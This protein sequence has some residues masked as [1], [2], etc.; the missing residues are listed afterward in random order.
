LPHHATADNDYSRAIG[1]GVYGGALEITGV[2]LRATATNGQTAEASA[3]V[4][5][6]DDMPTA[7]DLTGASHACFGEA[8]PV[9][10]SFQIK[11][12][13]DQGFVQ[14]ELLA[15]GS[16]L[17]LEAA[18]PTGF[19][20]LAG[21]G[22][23]DVSIDL[24]AGLG[25]W[26]FGAAASAAAAAKLPFT[27]V[28]QDGDGDRRTAVHNLELDLPAAIDLGAN[29]GLL[30][31]NEDALPVPLVGP[32]SPY[33][34][35]YDNSPSG[36]AGTTITIH[37]NSDLVKG[38]RFDSARLAAIQ[39]AAPG[40][41]YQLSDQDHTLQVWQAGDGASAAP[42]E[43]ARV[44]LGA[45]DATRDPLNPIVPVTATLLHNLISHG[46]AQAD[47]S[48]APLDFS[49]LPILVDLDGGD[50]APATD[51]LSLRI[52]DDVPRVGIADDYADPGEAQQLTALS[53]DS[54]TDSDTVTR[55]GAGGQ[56]R[57]SW[58]A[59]AANNGG[60]RTPTAQGADGAYGADGL[61]G[62]PE[63]PGLKQW[64][65]WVDVNRDGVED[66][67]EQFT[68]AN[69]AALNGTGPASGLEIPG[70]GR[71]KFWDNQPGNAAGWAFKANNN[72]T[73]GAFDFRVSIVDA[74]GDRDQQSHRLEVVPAGGEVDQN[75]TVNLYL[76]L[77]NSTSMQGSDPATIL[78]STKTRLEA[79]N[80]M[81]F[82]ALEQ[83]VARAGYGYYTGQ[84]SP[85]YNFDDSSI[86]NVLS[87]SASTIASVLDGYQLAD[88]PADGVLAGRVN[89]HVIKF[90]YI[91][92]Y[93]KTEFTPI[94]VDEGISIAR[95]VLLT[96]TPDSLYGNSIVGNAEWASRGLAAPT[97]L[98]LYQ[99][100]GTLA[101][102]LYA[103][104]EMLGG[105]TGFKNLLQAQLAA[106]APGSEDTTLVAMITDG[107]PERRYWW[108]NRPE[109]GS[110]GSAV[111]LPMALGGDPILSSGLLYDI[112]GNA[113]ITPTAAGVD[114][115]SLTQTAMNISL[116]DL[117]AKLHNPIDQLQVSAVGLGD[118]SGARFPQIYQDLFS[119]RT[120]DNS[121]SNWTYQQSSS[122]SLPPFLG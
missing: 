17:S 81:A 63:L 33:S 39:A 45:L 108:D 62:G 9:A 112:N 65:L 113:R 10:G 83:A 1:S 69:A 94:S 79:Q 116:N 51:G 104:T 92:E 99:G 4:T 96:A 41:T 44:A 15:N 38:L 24:A 52:Y 53:G 14:V 23:F 55:T 82:I 80:R 54:Y 78:A 87:N 13:A 40:L 27:F 60:L 56:V 49:Q 95:D 64:Q 114:Q 101:S 89:V 58:G 19:L 34:Q 106:T 57:G 3:N 22:R 16:R 84:N 73:P 29:G 6:L 109:R 26:S 35:T 117:A 111:P 18:T 66:A 97:S 74:D 67:A 122:A 59:L 43:V 25:Y 88:D 5:I 47:N 107:R 105:L 76:L 2:Q 115:W 28:V 85:F 70:L 119:N 93:Q 7:L 61:A 50:C 31:L 75:P 48:Y 30:R 100:P 12:G 120:F 103:G 102:N 98:D 86:N 36:G 11:P 8:T 32:D 71:F 46:A 37:R 42:R 90:G 121:A 91:V 68:G 77:D 118:G 20:E 72:A 21:L 110:T